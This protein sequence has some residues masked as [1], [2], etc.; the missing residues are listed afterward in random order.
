MEFSDKED[1]INA[2]FNKEFSKEFSLG[3]WSTEVDKSW[4]D[5]ILYKDLGIEYTL[6]PG[7]NCYKITDKK[8]WLLTRLKYG[9]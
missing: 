7:V 2:S 3:R 5:F 1:K 6:K 8:K 9:I 4:Y